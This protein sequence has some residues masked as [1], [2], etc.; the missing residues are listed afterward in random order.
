MSANHTIAYSDQMLWGLSMYSSV[1]HGDPKALAALV[2][3]DEDAANL[4]LLEAAT[5]MARQVMAANDLSLPD[6]VGLLI[7][8]RGSS[9]ALQQLVG[10]IKGR[11]MDTNRSP[12]EA[13]RGILGVGMFLLTECA[14]GNSR[15]LALEELRAAAVNTML[16]A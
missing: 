5:L 11:P 4:A 8:E 12:S 7:R 1:V 6:L 9:S 3:S 2:G 15:D 13:L 14:Q 10:R 16:A